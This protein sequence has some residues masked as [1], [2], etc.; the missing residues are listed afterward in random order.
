M[1][2]S[3][4]PGR[5]AS[6]DRVIARMSRLVIC[7]SCSNQIVGQARRARENARVGLGDDF[8]RQRI[9]RV[10]VLDVESSQRAPRAA[11]SRGPPMAFAARSGASRRSRARSATPPVLRGVSPSHDSARILAPGRRCGTSLS[12]A[13]PCS[14]DQRAILE[15]QPSRLAARLKRPTAAAGSRISSGATRLRDQRRRR[16]RRT[17]RRSPARRRARPRRARI[18]G[19]AS[20][21][22]SGQASVSPPSGAGEREMPRAADDER[23]LR[24]QPACG[25]RKA[26]EPV[27][28]DADDATASGLARR[29][30]GRALGKDACAF[31]FSAAPAK[32]GGS[33]ARLRNGDDVAAIL[34]LAG[35][36]ER[37]APQPIATRIGG[38]GG[39]DGLIAYLRA[40]RIDARDRRHPSLRRAD[41]AHTLSRP[42][43]AHT[44]RCWS[45][46]RAPWSAGRG[47]RW[48]EVD[49]AMPRPR[50]ARAM[51]RAAYFSPSVDS[52]SPL[53]QAAPQHLYAD[54]HHRPARRSVV[55]AASRADFRARAVL[56]RGRGHADARGE[57]RGRSS[58]RTAAARRPRP[59]SRPRGRCGIPVIIVARPHASAARASRMTRRSAGLAAT[60]HAP[61]RR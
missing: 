36:T 54:P 27:L 26:I 16:H 49:D 29:S 8:D 42:A 31:S 45:F 50:G 19:S 17:D 40:E 13:R 5:G 28:A 6:A 37:P 41:V 24:E 35:R 56:G 21:S 30:C 52:G 4:S 20:V 11:F 33:P 60:G 51:R 3:S 44:F 46:S 47:D 7:P 58:A 18:V 39:V 2:H 25:R 1:S 23:G 32:R 43:R 53:S 22:G 9:E 59:S 15:A 12:S 14:G 48:T 34:S 55:P 10:D 38:F 61:L 57:D